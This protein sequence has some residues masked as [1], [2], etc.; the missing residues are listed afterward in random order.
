MYKSVEKYVIKDFIK[1]NFVLVR[2]L[3]MLI[4]FLQPVILV[5][6]PLPAYLYYSEPFFSPAF[7]ISFLFLLS[8]GY[9]SSFL[10]QIL[11]DKRYFN[12]VLLNIGKTKF[13]FCY[14][15]SQIKF[16]VFTWIFLLL[17][18]LKVDNYFEAYLKVLL[19]LIFYVAFYVYRANKFTVRTDRFSLG[20]P[21][22][23]LLGVFIRP[24]AIHLLAYTIF[25]SFFIFVSLIPNYFIKSLYALFVLL[26]LFLTV[27]TIRRI[28]NNEIKKYEYFLKSISKIFYCRIIL[29]YFL[30]I[31]L[32]VLI[33]GFIFLY[34]T[35]YY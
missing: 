24:V 12:W 22:L 30:S 25:F 8:C 4:L 3:F 7:I 33:P 11:V 15:L 32:M 5:I 13:V 14:V 2:F 18:F 28:V 17:G 34:I 16:A 31:G 35:F 1:S 26:L 29:I 21:R 27:F 23:L 20:S 19:L 6:G 10:Y 9:V